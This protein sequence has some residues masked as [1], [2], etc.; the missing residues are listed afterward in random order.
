MAGVIGVTAIAIVTLLTNLDR[1]QT[2]LPLAS[3]LG[4]GFVG[5]IDD[6]I[7]VRGRGKGVAGLRSSLKFTMI[8]V[9]GL[10]LGWFLCQT[11]L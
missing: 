9:L 6:V 5:L 10:A 2:W 11:G 7:N 4:G 3:L 8:T 1:A